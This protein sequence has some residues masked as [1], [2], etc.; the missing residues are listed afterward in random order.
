MLIVWCRGCPEKRIFARNLVPISLYRPAVGYA[1]QIPAHFLAK[2]TDWG[3]T[4]RSMKLEMEGT[5]ADFLSRTVTGCKSQ[6]QR[7]RIAT[8]I[9]VLASQ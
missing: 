7:H 3:I 9:D 1:M 2:L 4:A 5:C 8:T 6:S